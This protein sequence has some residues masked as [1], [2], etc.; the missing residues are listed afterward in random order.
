SYPLADGVEVIGYYAPVPDSGLVLIT[1]TPLAV[2]YT[3]ALRFFDVPGFV[4]AVGF[5]VLIAVVAAAINQMI[6]PPLLRFRRATQSLMQGDFDMPMPDVKRQDELG[7]LALSFVAMR[8]Q[9]RVL[10]D[11]LEARI[12]ARSRDFDTTQEISRLTANQRDLQALMDRVVNLII[13]RFPNIYHAQVFLLNEAGTYALLRSSTGEAGRAL[14]E[15]GHRLA[16]GSLSVVGQAT[17]QR[18]LIVARDTASSQ[19]HRSNEFLPDTRSEMAIPLQVGTDLIGV[20]DVQSR[21]SEGFP[22]D[23][24]EVIETIAAQLAVGVDHARLYEQS[25][26]RVAIIEQRNR[27]ATLNAWNEYL[28]DRRQPGG[29]SR[30]AGLVTGTDLTS[31]REQA[32]AQAKLVVGATTER[33]TVPIAL[34]VRIRGQVIGAVEWELPAASFSAEQLGLAEELAERLAFSLDNARLFQESQRATERERV[35]NTIA[36]KLTSQNSIEAVLQT[37]AR[38]VGQA[39]RSPQVNVRLH[40][41]A[42]NGHPSQS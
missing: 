20:L 17:E 12:A 4:T 26:Q 5:L 38:E 14:L 40:E 2:A 13:E 33:G 7:D 18:R 19:V 8:D 11:D 24:T 23:Q 21:R 41:S 1:Q 6:A 30:E 25:L 42:Q 3:Q 32:R 34:P 15:R 35:V 10:I 36:R 39:L 29:V 31:L 28:T 37:A 9:V 27:Q 16:V 22:Q